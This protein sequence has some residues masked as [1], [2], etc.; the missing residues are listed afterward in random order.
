MEGDEDLLC[1]VGDEDEDR[2]GGV[3]PPMPLLTAASPA[4]A[5]AASDSAVGTGGGSGTPTEEMR[6]LFGHSTSSNAGSPASLATT[7]FF[8]RRDRQVGKWYRGGWS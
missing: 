1:F 2:D 7:Y 5:A 8:R 3:P 6:V 4:A